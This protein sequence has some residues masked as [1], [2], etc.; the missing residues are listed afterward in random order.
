MGPRRPALL[1]SAPFLLLLAA[2]CHSG[3]GCTRSGDDDPWI[4]FPPDPEDARDDTWRELEALANLPGEPGVAARSLEQA[5][6]AAR[7]AR[8]E[9]PEA[10]RDALLSRP[11]VHVDALPPAIAG[12]VAGLVRWHAEGGVLGAEVCDLE[13]VPDAVAFLD[14]VRWALASA[15]DDGDP[16]VR[17]VLHLARHLGRDGVALHGAV[18]QAAFEWILD[19]ADARGVPP[20]EIFVD[21]RPAAEDVARVIAR[22]HVCIERRVEAL[23]I[24]GLLTQWTEAR[25]ALRALGADLP[26]GQALGSHRLSDSSVARERA[27]VR[28]YFGRRFGGIAA[29]PS[30]R[31]RVMAAA[32]LPEPAE[33]L[34]ASFVVRASAHDLRF[35]VERWYE[36]VDRY[37]AFLA[38]NGD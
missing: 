26:D 23:G 34:P 29:G 25:D 14:L 17:A 18:A 16:R 22:E 37:D 10:L 38:S 11:G 13:R 1:R 15:E 7:G 6:A 32:T 35:L 30:D 12:A 21:H 31:A 27:W 20:S 33:E 3:A 28:T 2:L 8:D 5:A 19:W 36:T 9:V 4:G 24:E